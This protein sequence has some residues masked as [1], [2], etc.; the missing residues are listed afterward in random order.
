[1][2]EQPGLTVSAAPASDSRSHVPALDGVRGLA[3]LLVMI[4]HFGRAEVP[5]SGAAAIGFFAQFGWGGV[6]LFFVL[7]GFLICG[8]LLDTRD[9]PAFL[10]TF[11][12]RRTLRIFPLYF[13][14]LAAYIFVI[15]P[16]LPGGASDIEA[17][18]RW[19][20]LYVGNFDVA[21]HGWYSGTGS[22]ANHLWS[23]AI[24]EQFYL[25][26][27]FAV[28]LLSRRGLARLAVVCALGAL[29]LRVA[30]AHTGFPGRWGYVLT[31]TRVDAL[32]LGALLAL[33]A[34]RGD[35]LQRLVPIARVVAPLSAVFVVAFALISGNF[36]SES[37]RTLQ[38]GLPVLT[39]GFAALLVL[40]VASGEGSWIRGTF[41]SRALRFL[42]VYSYSLY[43]WHPL[44][45]ALVRRTGL[46]QASIV[47]PLGSTGAVLVT[48]AVKIA[49]A[50]LVAIVSYRV[51]EQPFLQLK[52]RLRAAAW[53]TVGVSS[54]A[55]SDA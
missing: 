7:S 40:A 52:N 2:V 33:A 48:L 15:A 19:L 6:D 49:V 34:R 41:E 14:F 50:T 3:A 36:D 51:I 31:F 5:G 39:L 17:R 1:M 4:F 21:A 11:Y 43:I 38:I 45:G 54:T 53:R 10:R 44:V 37:W 8:I 30:L 46:R 29:A 42:G 26:A 47:G 32:C 24:E 16:R 9:R 55:V 23:L 35:L 18:Q 22:H 12:A 28:L 27:P 20:W 25:L 13:A